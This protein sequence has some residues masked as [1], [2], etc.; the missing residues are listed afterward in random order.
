MV[1]FTSKYSKARE[2][3]GTNLSGDYYN[4]MALNINSFMGGVTDIW[5]KASDSE[6]GREKPKFH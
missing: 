5:L 1:I 6:F 2:D 3:I 4:L